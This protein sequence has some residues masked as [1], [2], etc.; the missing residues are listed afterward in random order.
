MLDILDIFDILNILPLYLNLSREIF[1]CI[2]SFPILSGAVVL[3]VA[4]TGGCP[5]IWEV[6]SDNAGRIEE[7]SPP[8]VY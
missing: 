6:F 8:F 2:L 4:V 1:G 5:P 3:R 7:E